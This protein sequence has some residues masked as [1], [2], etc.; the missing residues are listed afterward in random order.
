MLDG[1]GMGSGE[2]SCPSLLGTVPKPGPPA[3]L[4]SPGHP[5]EESSRDSKDRAL[6]SPGANAAQSREN[7]SAKLRAAAKWQESEL[8][9]G[10][11][12][13]QGCETFFICTLERA[14]EVGEREMKIQQ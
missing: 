4:E 1:G 3:L 9:L 7:T 6:H 14:R 12:A 13:K 2:G 8:Q 11:H 5:A 10:V